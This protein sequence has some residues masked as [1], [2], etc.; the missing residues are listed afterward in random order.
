VNRFIAAV[1]RTAGAFLGLVAAITFAEALLRYSVARHIPDGF[2]LGQ[3]L[4]GIAICWG[5][6]T[7]TYADRHVTVDALY[8]VVS[9]R[10]QRIFDVTAHTL[11]FVFFA[12]FGFMITFKVYDILRAGERSIDLNLPIWAGYLIASL[13]IVAT[14]I[15]AGARWW[16]VVWTRKP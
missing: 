15:L 9:A 12:L 3:M 5:I 16:Q 10:W 11:N 8:T 14:V 6:A 13:G 2:I 1:E 7:A 4:Q